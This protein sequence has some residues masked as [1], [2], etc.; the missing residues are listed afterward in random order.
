MRRALVLGA[1]IALGLYANGAAAAPPTATEKKL[2]KDV[3][4]LKAQV[5]ALRS[6]LKKVKTAA[7]DAQDIEPRSYSNAPVGVNFLIAGYAYTRGGLSLDPALP[8]SDVH[9]R[10][11]SLVAAYA[12]A[13]RAAGASRRGGQIGAPLQRP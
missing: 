2:Q 6:D 13:L 3:A 10:T 5:K 12:R 8:V 11:S 1:L 9:L 4:T 7:A